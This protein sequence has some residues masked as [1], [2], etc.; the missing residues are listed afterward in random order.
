M[1]TFEST[2]LLDN[3]K[4]YIYPNIYMNMYETV[5]LSVIKHIL[6]IFIYIYIPHIYI[7]GLTE[8]TD[9]DY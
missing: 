8:L 7:Y 6:Y 5:K 2:Y 9:K 1:I 3:Y 4:H